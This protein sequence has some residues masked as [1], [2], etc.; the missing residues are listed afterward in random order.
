MGVHL[1]LNNYL[2]YFFYSSPYTPNYLFSC[3][4]EISATFY[5]LSYFLVLYYFLLY[6]SFFSRCFSTFLFF[7]FHYSLFSLAPGG[8]KRKALET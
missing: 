2:H 4:Q 7:L 6:L 5:F 3:R 1:I 8:K